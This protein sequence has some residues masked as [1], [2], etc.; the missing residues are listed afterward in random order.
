MNQV[1]LNDVMS[2]N[3]AGSDDFDWKFV[4][5]ASPGGS[6]IATAEDTGRFLRALNEGTLFTD[7]EQAI[8]SSVCDYAHADLVSGYRIIAGY[9]MDIDADVA[10]AV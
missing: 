8:Y 9:H 1:N 3:D 2:G 10:E 7:E 5:Y 6:M 4:D